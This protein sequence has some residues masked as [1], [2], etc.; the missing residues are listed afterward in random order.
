MVGYNNSE[1]RGEK[2]EIIFLE[3]LSMSMKLLLPGLIYLQYKA[4]ITGRVEDKL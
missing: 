1:I 3:G 2:R 4:A